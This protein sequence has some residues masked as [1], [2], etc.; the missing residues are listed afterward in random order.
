MISRPTPATQDMN[1]LAANFTTIRVLGEGGFGIVKLVK[2]RQDGQLFAVKSFKQTSNTVQALQ[3]AEKEI[4]LLKTL[5]HPNIVGFHGMGFDQ[6]ER[7]IILEYCAGGD[8]RS[9]IHDAASQ[10]KPIPHHRIQSIFC[11]MLL[12]LHYCHH[13]YKGLRHTLLHRDLK[14]ENVLLNAAGQVKLADFGLA[15]VMANGL[16]VTTSFVGTSGYLPPELVAGQP[17][18][19]KADIF[20]LGCI[21]FE[22]CTLRIPNHALRGV[23]RAREFLLPAGHS[24][25]MNSLVPMLLSIEPARRPSTSDLLASPVIACWLQ[26]PWPREDDPE[27]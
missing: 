6:K 15:K 24:A 13:S 7:Y 18:D 4:A 22:L 21:L 9:M 3:L 27:R 14:P 10:R 23:Q 25:Q 26:M 1:N 11:Q 19:H 17:Y 5:A 8:L 16:T 20:N 12:A 2:S